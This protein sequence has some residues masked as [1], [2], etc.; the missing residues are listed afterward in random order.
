MFQNVFSSIPNILSLSY[1]AKPVK[2]SS[3]FHI[4]MGFT[5]IIIVCCFGGYNYT[6]FSV[7]LFFFIVNIDFCFSVYFCYLCIANDK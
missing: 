1:A 4:F 7:R 3:K 5:C 2:S 6:S